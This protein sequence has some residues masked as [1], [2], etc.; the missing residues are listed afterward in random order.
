M[1]HVDRHTGLMLASFGDLQV[2]LPSA[3]VLKDRSRPPTDA[4]PAPLFDTLTD[5]SRSG[6]QDTQAA[7]RHSGGGAAV[8]GN[9]EQQTHECAHHPHGHRAPMGRQC[10]AVVHTQTRRSLEVSLTK[11]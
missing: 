4:I 8:S 2:P 3:L 11:L 7:D 5:S 1:D 6:T 9:G 10:G